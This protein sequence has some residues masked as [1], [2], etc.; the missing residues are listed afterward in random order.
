MLSV[1]I[2]APGESSR[3]L[4]I[5][6]FPCIIGRQ[7]EVPW[8]LKSWRVAKSHARLDVVG[9][10]LSISDLGS[11]SGTWVNGQRITQYGPLGEADEIQ[12]AGYRIR[13]QAFSSDLGT[14]N[15]RLIEKQDLSKNQ[16]GQRGV[17]GERGLGVGRPDETSSASNLENLNDRSEIELHWRR[18]LHQQLL[19][20]ID[21][22]RHDI[23]LLGN[24]A[25]AALVSSTLN[26]LLDKT[27][28]FP[29]KLDRDEVILQVC[30]EAI[31][32]G[33]LENL[34][35]DESIS[36]IMVNGLTPIYVERHGRLEQTAWRFTNAES[37]RSVIDRI[38]A[39]IG[40]R[41]DEASPMVDARLQDGSRV[42]A[43]IAPLAVNGPSITIRRF[44]RRM[45]GPS[46]LA[47]LGS[48]S[49]EMIEFLRLCV[50]QRMNIIVAGGTG[51]GKTTL[52]N[53]LSSMIDEG[54]RIVTIEDAAELRLHHQN[55]VTL[56]A[57][58]ANAEG[59]GQVQIRDLVKNALRM[60]PDRIVVGECRG[61]EALDMLQ[62]MN[63]GHDGSLT[64]VHAN[65]PRDVISRLEVMSLMAGMDIP[66]QAI[67]E[68]VASAVN[69]IVQ[70][71]R[72]PDGSRRITEIT[73]VTGIE[74]NRVLMQAI[75][76]YRRD[77][78]AHHS[79]G[80][81][82]T[83]QI[84]QFIDGLNL[85]GARCDLSWFEQKR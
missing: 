32:L 51:S 60:R 14:S 42:N 74:G 55:L 59:R 4:Q 81:E 53:V 63:T 83:G 25:L 41:I 73:E 75:F 45:M 2:E 15:K 54:E 33:P 1:S 80:F 16:G 85:Q 6:A 18:R 17:E 31:G 36:E 71:S 11:L 49:Q 12:I 64:T 48:A 84:P 24:E 67:R 77:T 50:E 38:V 40:R 43:V 70:Q 79:A 61:G 8:N 27:E 7:S 19:D 37:I 5:D 26:E 69:I 29:G 44:N 56:E 21:L 78:D 35:N 9:H 82:A 46:D 52:L 23:R 58:P 66:V 3:H 13:L 30:H 20:T 68:Q 28:D 10:T 47:R 22:R 76:R 62:A 65:S 72:F 34:L 57:R 39:P